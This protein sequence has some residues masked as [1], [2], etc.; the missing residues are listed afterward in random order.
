MPD[1]GSPRQ[2]YSDSDDEGSQIDYQNGEQLRHRLTSIE[3]ELTMMGLIGGDIPEEPVARFNYLDSYARLYTT[4]FLL[5]GSYLEEALS[6]SDQVKAQIPSQIEKPLFYEPDD[7]GFK[8]K[9]VF[10]R[11]YAWH[12][13]K[14]PENARRLVNAIE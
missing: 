2:D 7:D 10:L 5:N 9:Y 6:Y 13:D 4:R 11:V 14:N 12:K 1:G 8:D 3:Q